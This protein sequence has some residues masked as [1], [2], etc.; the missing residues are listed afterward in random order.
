MDIDVITQYLL[1]LVPAVSAAATIIITGVSV[2]K[3]FKK[4]SKTTNARIQ[5]LERSNEALLADNARLRAELFREN[6][7]KKIQSRGK[8]NNEKK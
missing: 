6:N 5:A 3:S 8:I 2:V 1:S 4:E 7:K